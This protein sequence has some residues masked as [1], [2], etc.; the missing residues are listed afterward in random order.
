MDVASGSGENKRG[1]PD[2][3]NSSNSDSSELNDASGPDLKKEK[4]EK[5]NDSGSSDSSNMYVY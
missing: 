3:D 1:K 4:Q 2:Y 5:L